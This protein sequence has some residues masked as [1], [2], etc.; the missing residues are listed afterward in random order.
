MSQYE[1]EELQRL[2]AV[3][4]RLRQVTQ[5]QSEIAALLATSAIA[6]Q[7]SAAEI[8]HAGTICVVHGDCEET[9]VTKPANQTTRQAPNTQT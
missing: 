6:K 9:S 7:A 5:L 4:Q 8:R 1:Y 2:R 3:E